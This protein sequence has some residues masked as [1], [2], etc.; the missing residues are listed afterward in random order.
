[1]DNLEKYGVTDESAHLE[2]ITRGNNLIAFAP[3]GRKAKKEDLLKILPDLT[4]LSIPAGSKV[5]LLAPWVLTAVSAKNPKEGPSG[6]DPKENIYFSA[7][8]G[9][10]K[11][12]QRIAAGHMTQ[13]FPTKEQL[14]DETIIK[15]LSDGERKEFKALLKDEDIF[16][17]TGRMGEDALVLLETAEWEVVKTFKY[18]QYNSTTNQDLSL[19]Q[20]VVKKAETPKKK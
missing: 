19:T 12:E 15:G 14:D 5:I 9:D 10:S 4:G 3:G 11:K 13:R 16:V 17:P 2:A 18:K 8:I 6:R 1:M 7:Y 20:I